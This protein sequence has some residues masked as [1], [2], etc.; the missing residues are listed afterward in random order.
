MSDQQEVKGLGSVSHAYYGREGILTGVV[1]LPER[2]MHD[3]GEHPDNVR[4]LPDVVERLRASG[5]W[6]RLFVLYPRYARLEDLARSHDERYVELV[7]SAAADA[8]VWLDTDTRVSRGSFDAAALAAGAALAAVDAVA[9]EAYWR[10]DSLFAL[11]RPPGHHA[12]PDRAMGFC[13]FNHASVAARYALATYPFERVAIVDWDV[14]HGNG[15]QEIHW[16]DPSVLFVSLHQWPLYPGTGWLEEVGAGDGEGYTVNVPM[17][18]G[19]GDRE[20]GEAFDGVVEPALRAFAPELLIVSA[21]Q[22]CHAA[23]TLSNQ[24]VS[25]VGFRAMAERLSRVASELGIGLVVL[26]EGG[27]NVS[28]LPQLDHAILGG[29]GGFDTPTQDIFAKGAPPAEDWPE[30]LSAVRERV[31]RYWPEV[32]R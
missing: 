25:T 7:R 9:M 29:L 26:H 4:R 6:E 18:P 16:E 22:D 3:P 28:T 31:A 2:G 20:Y 21:G 23:D 10:P 30:R 27:Y 15:T 12:T 19:S 8:P 11:I 5:D 32:G 14:H 1:L 24:M 13:L 17:P